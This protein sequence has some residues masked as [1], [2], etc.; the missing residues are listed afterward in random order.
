MNTIKRRGETHYKPSSYHEVVVAES[1]LGVSSLDESALADMRIAHND[2]LRSKHRL[3]EKTR[4]VTHH[5]DH[6]TLGLC[7]VR[8]ERTPETKL[9]VTCSPAFVSPSIEPTVSLN[10]HRE[11]QTEET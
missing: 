6:L 3:L 5:N 8:I 9:V 2:Q 11:N 10:A 1:A 4:T 7:V